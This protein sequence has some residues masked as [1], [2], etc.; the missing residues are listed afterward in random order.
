MLDPETVLT[1][2]RQDLAAAD[3][4]LTVAQVA[5]KLGMS[6][7]FVRNE[8]RAGVLKARTRPRPSGRT[9]IRIPEVMFTNY[10]ETTWK[11][12]KRGRSS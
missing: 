5:R 12:W 1:E 9:V 11:L 10:W 7:Q 6:S 2:A 8:I 3:R 4:L